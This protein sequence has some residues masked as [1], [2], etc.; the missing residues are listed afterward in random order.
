MK[1][2]RLEIYGYGKWVQQSFELNDQMQILYGPNESGK[3][4]IQSFIRS[5]LFGFPS[6]RRRKNQINRFEPKH[7]DAYGG[8]LL[9]T[10]TKV[11]DVWIERTATDF[12]LTSPDGDVYDDTLLDQ[13]LGGLDETLFDNFYSFT[14]QNLQELSNIGAD[15]LNDYFLSIGTMGSD[16]FLTIAKE[17]VKESDALYRPQGSNPSLN[18]A[19]N[20]YQSLAEKME[21]AQK[22]NASYNSLVQQ[23]DQEVETIQQLNETLDEIDAKRI[24]TDQLMQRYDIYLKQIQAEKQLKALEWTEIDS[25]APTQIAYAKQMIQEN[26]TQCVKN[27]ERIRQNQQQ[28]A[29]LTRLNWAKNHQEERAQWLK[30]TNAIKETQS[31]IEHITRLLVDKQNQLQSIATKS[32]FYPEKMPDQD[33]Y[34][35]QL[36]EGSAIYEEINDTQ[37]AID[38]THAERRFFID[39]RK[40]QQ[41]YSTM[42][43]QQIVSLESQRLNDEERLI[44]E[45]SLKEYI[46]GIVFIVIGIIALIQQLSANQTSQNLMILAIA[47]IVIGVIYSGFIFNKHR[48]LY[49]AFNHSPIISKLEQLQQDEQHYLDHSKS[50]GEQITARDAQLDNLSKRDEALTDQAQQWLTHLGFYPT[51][52]LELVL[53]TNPVEEYYRA[54][55]QAEEYKARLDQLA[56]EV[57]QWKETIRPL[58]DRFPLEEINTRAIIRHHEEI[59]AELALT[60]QQGKQL[61]RQ[62]QE[63]KDAITQSKESIQEHEQTIQ[64]IFEQ[65]DSATMEDF[66]EKLQV[67]Q[68]IKQLKQELALYQEQTEDHLEA[69]HNIESKQQLTEDY[70]KIRLELENIRKELEPHRSRRADLTAEVRRMERD[71]TVQLLTQSLADK[72]TEIRDLILS[73]GKKRMGMAMLY[74]TLR[75]G[76]DNPLPEMTQHATEIFDKLSY[77]RYKQVKIN[78]K[79]IRVVHHSDIIFEPYELSQGTLEQ[80]YVALRLAF[81]ISAK[82]LVK[83]PIIIDDA[84]V[85]FDEMRKM[86]MYRVLEE[87]STIMQ[88]LYFT[89]DDQVLEMFREDQWLDLTKINEQH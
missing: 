86:S 8:R 24:Q 48:Q 6:K 45:T 34:E 30:K 20:E 2:K 47:M 69:L 15:Q 68:Q 61:E 59:E 65:T 27:E 29:E 56:L 55:E 50:L 13:I 42:I 46:L 62:I 38:D 49:H 66:I 80:L 87:L 28:M 7:S 77:G 74:Q 23:L 36:E 85:N 83:M 72:E 18:K 79:N 19:L 81:I 21:Q 75:K 43:R 40:E 25:E 37:K 89:F 5:I 35:A 54:K 22:N 33:E 17:L 53:K 39:Q 1:I 76:L 58:L 9:L 31:E 78:K 71:G 88:V 10:D 3:S 73:W 63:A 41:S 67:N 26:Q 60:E 52:D 12:S 44:Q 51:A 70:Q 16:K 4:T 11:G 14:L 32:Q 64:T 84:F 82:E 57:T